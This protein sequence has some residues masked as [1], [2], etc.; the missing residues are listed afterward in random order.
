MV[1]KQLC[2]C[3]GMLWLQKLLFVERFADFTSTFCWWMFDGSKRLRKVLEI[4]NHVYIS[5]LSNYKGEWQIETVLPFVDALQI[6]AT[7][8][9]STKENLLPPEIDKRCLNQSLSKTA[10]FLR[11]FNPNWIWK[12]GQMFLRL[13][14]ADPPWQWWHQLR[15]IWLEAIF[16]DVWHTLW[17][18]EVI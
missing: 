15:C 3:L 1:Q 7:E 10:C 16:K 4:E 8:L 14:C 13:V 11:W 6:Q 5:S 18:G 12:L 2:L 17:W 9:P